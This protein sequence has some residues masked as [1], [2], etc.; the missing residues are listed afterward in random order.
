M[1]IIQFLWSGLKFPKIQ[2][3]KKNTHGEFMYIVTKQYN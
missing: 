1:I 2:E 3:K